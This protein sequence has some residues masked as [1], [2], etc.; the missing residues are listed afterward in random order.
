MKQAS[1]CPVLR[2]NQ[3]HSSVV[4]EICHSRTSLLSINFNPRFL[5]RHGREIPCP[6]PTEQQT[7]PRVTPWN[8]RLVG[9]KIL[10][11]KDILVSVS[12][13]IRNVHAE[14]RSKLSLSW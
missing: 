5:A 2:D 11:Q 12:V 14:C 6:I 8:F 4:I 7:P 13:E 1:R 9:K 3:V 10:A